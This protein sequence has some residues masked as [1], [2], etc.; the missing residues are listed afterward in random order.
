MEFNDY[1]EASTIL[2]NVNIDGNQTIFLGVNVS[3]GP[4]LTPRTEFTSVFSAFY[5]DV[6]NRTLNGGYDLD[7]AGDGGTGVILDGETF[8][9]V[10][11][12]GIS[13]SIFFK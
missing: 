4:E 2:R 1:G 7:V 13:T 10:G 8:S 3:G 9:I 5:C 11:G 6:A 12:A